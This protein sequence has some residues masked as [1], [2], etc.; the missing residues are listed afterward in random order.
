MAVAACVSLQACLKEQEDVFDKSPSARMTEYLDNA[1]KILTAPENGW[2][3]SY[4]PNSKLS[5][6]GF[7]YVV[8]FGQESVEVGFELSDDPSATKTSLYRMG[9]DNGPVLSFDTNNAFLHY[10]ST[11]SSKLYQGYGGDFEFTLLEVEAG[12]VKMQGRRSGNII[13]MY[14]M[15][16]DMVEY[17]TDINKVRESFIVDKISGVIGGQEVTASVDMM[18][19]QMDVSAGGETVRKAFRFTQD[20]ICLYEP[21]EVGGVHVEA[22]SFDA[23]TYKI[24]VVGTSDVLQAT[25]PATY[26]RWEDYAGDYWLI[27]NREDEADVQ[28]DSIRV[29]IVLGERNSTCLMKGLNDKYDIVWNYN[30]TTWTLSWKVQTLGYIES[31]GYEVRL[32]AHDARGGFTWGSS[33]FGTTEWNGSKEAPVYRIIPQ[34]KWT[35]GSNTRYANSFYLCCWDGTTRKSYPAASTGWQFS[36][37]GKNAYRVMWLYSLEKIN[38]TT[39]ESRQL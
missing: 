18:Y 3:M 11:P 15:E 21:V 35:S 39:Q 2:L 19:Q 22:F 20:G 32:C 10:F 30:A 24:G 5:Y 17:F 31:N 9:S 23:D 25:Q 36:L 38:D 26:R 37:D 33:V 14:P 8:K 1:K 27:Y 12:H 6:G 34:Y 28:Y 29:T 16:G 13:M 7:S 4:W